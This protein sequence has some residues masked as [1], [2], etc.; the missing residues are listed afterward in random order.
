MWQGCI[1]G[2]LLR[3]RLLRSVKQPGIKDI[4]Y[5]EQE[6]IRCPVFSL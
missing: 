4:E 5:F 2:T 1:G 3:S 6:L